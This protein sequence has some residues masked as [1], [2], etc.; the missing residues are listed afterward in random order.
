M[1][2][3]GERRS[4]ATRG[5]E[6]R[7]AE[8][9]AAQGPPGISTMFSRREKCSA[10]IKSFEQSIGMLSRAVTRRQRRR[11]QGQRQQQQRLS[12]DEGGADDSSRAMASVP[13]GVEGEH[14]SR[15]DSECVTVARPQVLPAYDTKHL[16]HLQC[17]LLDLSACQTAAGSPQ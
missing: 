10:V 7:S 2:W 13:D 9:D 1:I 5:V 15:K 16:D 8:E 12:G 17:Y 3:R 6:W 11:R 14:S 4:R